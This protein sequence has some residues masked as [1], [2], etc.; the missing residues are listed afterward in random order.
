[1][2]DPLDAVRAYFA[3]RMSEHGST[4]RGVDWSTTEAQQVRFAQV[5]NVRDHDGP[6]TIADWGCGYGALYDFLDRYGLPFTYVGYDIT[7]AA[8]V[9]A[10]THH[11]GV[12]FVG[13]EDALPECEFVVASGVYNIKLDAPV[14]EWR[15]YVHDQLERMFAKATRGIASTFLTTYSDPP[16]R[17]PDLF[18]ADPLQLFDFAKRKLSPNVALLHDYGHWDFTLIVRKAP[19]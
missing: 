5:M 13:D 9:R 10:R 15:A 12:R 2:S 14:D 1:V 17:R 6:F 8:L 18:Y 11:P 19:P 3:R 16:K 7:P 4:P